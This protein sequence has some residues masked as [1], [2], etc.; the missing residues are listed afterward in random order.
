M[1]ATNN[2]IGP[3]IKEVV[4]YK[5]VS[6]VFAAQSAMELYNQASRCRMVYDKS[7]FKAI[8]LKRVDESVCSS[9]CAYLQRQLRPSA[10]DLIC[11]RDMLNKIA[12]KSIREDDFLM[13]RPS[14]SA[15]KTNRS[16]CHTAR[17]GDNNVL[18]NSSGKPSRTWNRLCDDWVQL[19]LPPYSEKPL[20]YWVCLEKI[21]FLLQCSYMLGPSDL[22]H[23]W[24]NSFTSFNSTFR[25]Y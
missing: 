8:F 18:M 23:I 15:V 6:R 7:R 16:Y 3:V 17:S 13:N 22:M 5:Q 25:S 19:S 21:H 9:M 10:T 14:P 2:I 1:C 4:S 20:Y 24:K 11:D 12:E